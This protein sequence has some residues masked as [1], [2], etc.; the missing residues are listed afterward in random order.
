MVVMVFIHFSEPAGAAEIYRVINTAK[1]G[2]EGGFDFVVADSEGRRLYIPRSAGDNSRVS[3]FDLDSLKLVGE[4][5][6][7]KG[8][9]GVAIDPTSQ[10]GFTSS[11]PVVMFDTKTLQTVKTIDVEGNPDEILFDPFTEQVFVFSHQAPNATVINGKDGTVVGTFDLGGAP[12]QAVSDRQGHVYVDLED[13]DNVAVVDAKTL[14]VTARYDLGGK[15]GGPSGLALDSKNR[16][17]FVCCQNPQTAVILNADNGKI[18]ST[19]PIGNGVDGTEFN[20]STMEAFSSQRDGTLTI[21]K[22]NGP[23]NFEVEQN[24]DT[25]RGA[26]TCTLDEKTNKIMLITA[27][28]DPAAQGQGGQGGRNRWLPDSFTIL[29]VGK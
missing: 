3:V 23:T 11:K 18:I 29:V 10:H 8:V 16:V 22:E 9:H 15:G 6:H 4:I 17:L 19:L 5:A 27:E 21:I 1:V 20:S 2:G 12:E 26:K 24:V 25:K 13:K 14:K 7:T 28:P